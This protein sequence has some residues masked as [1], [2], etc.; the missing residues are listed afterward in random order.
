MHRKR[1]VSYLYLKDNS[2]SLALYEE[3]VYRK[4]E[5]QTHNN[6]NPF[7]PF[8]GICVYVVVVVVVFLA[9]LIPTK[10][11]DQETIED[12]DLAGPLVCCLMLGFFLLLTGKVHFGYIYGF[13]LVGCLL[14]S[15]V[16]SL[17]SKGA[18]QDINAG[19]DLYRTV[20]IYGYCLLPVVILAALHVIIDL[21][22]IFGFLLSIII[23]AWC[24]VSATRFV[25]IALQMREQRWLIVYPT[26]LF[27]CT[28]AM[29]SIF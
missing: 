22:S 1:W 13:G 21:N 17:M 4:R 11:I 10:S 16:L 29:I 19:L 7:F 12:T 18:H 25:E 24:T 6:F 8:F 23:I 26:A 20:S 9:V 15:T 28:F 14:L 2:L 5:K 3:K 27:Y